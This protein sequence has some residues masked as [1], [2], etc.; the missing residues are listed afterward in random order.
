MTGSALQQAAGLAGLRRVVADPQR[1]ARRL[2]LA[3]ADV[4]GAA[5][6]VAGVPRPGVLRLSGGAAEPP[7]FLAT[8]ADRLAAGLFDLLGAPSVLVA[9][10]ASGGGVDD[11][12]RGVL[13][14]HFATRWGLDPLW[15][16]RALPVL[17]AGCA[18]ADPDDLAAA[19]LALQR[20]LPGGDPTADLPAL[21]RT[22]GRTGGRMHPDAAALIARLEAGWRPAR[23]GVLAALAAAPGRASGWIGRR[24]GRGDADR[25]LAWAGHDRPDLPPE[26]VAPPVPVLW[27]LGKTGAGKSSVIRL[28]TGLDGAEIGTGFAP[29]TRTS[30]AFDHPADQP[31]LRFLDTRG[32]GEAGYDPAEDLAV[33]E[34]GSHAVLAVVRLDDPV[35]GEV[36]EVL[37]KVRRTSPGIPV[38]VLHTG[39]DLVPDP[40]Q[41]ARARRHTQ[42][43][44]ESA[45]GG[46]L[47]SLELA[48]PDAAL[49]KATAAD[50]LIAALSAFLPEAALFLMRDAAPDAEAR[51]FARHKALVFW[52]AGA[53]GASDA[54]PV[55]GLVT[56]P[57]LQAAMLNA[58]AGRYGVEWTR[59]R[60]TAF[61][62]A[63][64]SALLLRLGAGLGLRQVVKLIPVYGQTV[65]A[66]SAATLSFATTLA[67]GRAAA[68]WL[69]HDRR[70]DPLD[71]ETL[72]AHY[73]DALKRAVHARP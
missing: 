17:E 15:L 23:R 64:G 12:A 61:A 49:H 27:L 5:A 57:G 11:R 26:A 29:C 9:A 22:L 73:T 6:R 4:A 71:V 55:V 35:Q 10:A 41:R 31:V 63:L 19:L 33:C 62:A 70:G 18:G 7:A 44:L 42:S 13:K 37:A 2:A 60:A 46:T 66:A 38:L 25:V 54:A 69:H 16:D 65:G 68:A 51:D 40:E 72:R 34:R 3:G 36:I 43:L 56:V 14:H 30:Q 20:D 32:L 1:L 52:Y 50:D 48:L 59:P 53:A 45:A 47:P 21:L 28:L 8:P 39:A 67:L 24:F 58:L